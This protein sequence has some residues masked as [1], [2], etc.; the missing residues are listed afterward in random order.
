M[1]DSQALCNKDN[2]EATVAKNKILYNVVSYARQRLSQ[3]GFRRTRF[4]TE[5]SEKR[6][7]LSYKLTRQALASDIYLAFKIAV[8][9]FI[10][11][12]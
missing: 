11:E 10:E 3:E 9:Y 1:Q 5:S 12:Q 4:R 6:K 8:D 2:I 7:P